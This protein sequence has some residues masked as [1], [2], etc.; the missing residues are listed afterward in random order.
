MKPATFVEFCSNIGVNLG[1]A[2]RVFALVAFD[3]VD[4]ADL[5]DDDRD[6][7]RLLFGPVDFVPPLARL[8]IAAI[9][10]RSSGKTYT[11][12]SLR[13][14]HLALTVQVSQLS[15]G[16]SASA[17]LVAPDIRLARIG[18]RYAAGAIDS[19]KPLRRLVVGRDENSI[20][21][22]R[23]REVT[24]EVLPA[25]RGGSAVRGRSLVF[26]GMDEAAFFRDENHA[27]N[28]IDLAL[29]I[30]PR[31]LPG[32][33]LV[34]ASSPWAE[35]GYL[36]DLYSTN[37]GDP[38]ASLVARAPT[39]LMR[40]TPENRDAVAVA[41]AADADHAAREFGA[42]FMAAGTGQFF[43]PSLVDACFEDL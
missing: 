12:L 39:L 15:P 31:L 30:T 8:V 24:I 4:P 28:D 19:S 16:E 7:A 34:C 26:G 1:P 32:A 38:H 11:M 42:Q 41:E 35:S 27:V 3:G 9:C 13:A 2:Q 6:L 33:Q 21:I 10:G 5:E 18:L 25:T 29:A 40:D 37:F 22:R 20:T 36:W 14:V 23:E 43:E 17:I